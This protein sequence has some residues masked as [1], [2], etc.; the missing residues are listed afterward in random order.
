MYTHIDTS[1]LSYFKVPS[2]LSTSLNAEALQYLQ[3]YL[4]AASVTLLWIA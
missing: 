2:M 1:A 3:G 4:Q